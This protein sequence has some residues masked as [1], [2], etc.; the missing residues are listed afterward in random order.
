MFKTVTQVDLNKIHQLDLNINKTAENIFLKFLCNA[1][2]R[3]KN[4]TFSKYMYLTYMRK[5]TPTN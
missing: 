4:T 3:I 1:E 5:T 2:V